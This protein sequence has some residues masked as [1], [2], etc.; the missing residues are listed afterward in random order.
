MLREAL[1]AALRVS[2]GL[3][4]EATND[5]SRSSVP[6]ASTNC[7]KDCRT[8]FQSDAEVSHMMSWR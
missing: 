5:Y 7:T 1:E 6:T 4:S 2:G 3:P 8:D